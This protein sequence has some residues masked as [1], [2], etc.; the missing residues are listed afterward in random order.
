M[1]GAIKSS[2]LSSSGAASMTWRCSSPILVVPAPPLYIQEKVHPKAIID[3][4]RRRSRDR[5][6]DA[7][8]NLF[9]DFNGLPREDAKT[10]FYQHDAHWSNGWF[11][12]VSSS[13]GQT[14]LPA[15]YETGG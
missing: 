13:Q 9:A 1:S 2:T 3:D 14:A 5:Q 10:E 12:H 4:L 8:P 7:E 15:T 11:L 6:A